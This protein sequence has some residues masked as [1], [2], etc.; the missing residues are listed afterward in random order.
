MSS[1]ARDVPDGLKVDVNGHVFCTGSGALWVLEPSGVIIGKVVT[2]DAARNCA[3]GDADM[4]T[5]YI[6]ALNT[7]YR[8]RLK[9]PGICA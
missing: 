9:S 5:L 1:S 7:L 6:T 3:F 4:K 8:I 2:P